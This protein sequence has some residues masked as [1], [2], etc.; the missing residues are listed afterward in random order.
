M[1]ILNFTGCTVEYIKC[2]KR[3]TG[4]FI[5]QKDKYLGTLC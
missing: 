1:D 3:E 2:L 4:C 5:G